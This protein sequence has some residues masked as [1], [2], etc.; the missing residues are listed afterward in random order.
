MNYKVFELQFNTGVHI[1]NGKLTD[2]ESAIMADTIFSALCQEAAALYGEDGIRR[3]ASYVE[4]DQLRLSD[5]MP[6]HGEEYYI[7]RPM[8]RIDSGQTGDSRQKK[9]FKKLDYIRAG[10]LKA[11][12]DGALDA[13]RELEILRQ[14]GSDRIQTMACI[15]EG[16]TA[17][18]YPVGV[19]Y[20]GKGWGLY[21]ILAYTDDD[22]LRF[23]E[24]LMES[25]EWSGIGG[26]RSAGLG[27]FSLYPGRLPD[28][29]LSGLKTRAEA[30]QYMTL[31]VSMAAE[32]E[33]KE[34][35]ASAQYSVIR[36][37]GFVASA[38]Y[39]DTLVR[40]KDFYM[41][42]AGATFGKTF[43][44]VLQDVSSGGNHPVY[45]YGKP[46]FLEVGK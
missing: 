37:S 15:D 32:D 38:E 8:M 27:K 24:E 36:R 19:F 13:N 46:L 17:V 33:L 1:G 6:V 30:G 25:L 21:I 40:K 18:P 10:S 28:S 26:K 42:R 43:G 20:F 31:S 9:A 16:K 41:F 14:M 4:A 45:R 29:F 3:L 39:A 5:A 22:V 7:P 23:A 11:Y 34:A 44:G 35:V 2:S 12:L